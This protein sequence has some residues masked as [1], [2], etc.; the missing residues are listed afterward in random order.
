[1]VACV[2]S[3]LHP[4][5]MPASG[6]RC[7]PRGQALM[8]ICALGRTAEQKTLNTIAQSMQHSQQVID[9]MYYMLEQVRFIHT[10]FTVISMCLF[11]CVW[12][13]SAAVLLV[14]V[15]A[16]TGWMRACVPGLLHAA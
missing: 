7:C 16:C 4:M 3:P 12:V 14:P 8:Q 13:F 11:V 5:H 15:D 6:C 10:L 9:D 1:V 2:C